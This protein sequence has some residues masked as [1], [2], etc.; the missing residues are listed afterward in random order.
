MVAQIGVKTL[1]IMPGSPW[2][3]GRCASLNGSMH[4][5][6]LNGEI[7]YTLAESRNL[8]EAWRRHYNT[9]RQHSPL[10]YRPPAP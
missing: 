1:Y 7:F 2:E 8:I 10:S 6:L 4:D 9:G 5:E 3:N